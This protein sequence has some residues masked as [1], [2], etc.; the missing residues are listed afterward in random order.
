MSQPPLPWW[1]GNLG[2][3]NPSQYCLNPSHSLPSGT[4]KYHTYSATCASWELAIQVNIAS[5]LH[6]HCHQ[7]RKVD[8]L[9]F[10]LAI[11]VNIA[12]ILHPHSLPSGTVNWTHILQLVLPGNWQ[13][14][15]M[16]PQ[17]FTYIAIG[18]DKLIHCPLNGQSK[19]NIASIL[20]I[21]CHQV[22]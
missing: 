18:Y 22:R 16:L 13:S 12:S 9:S 2:P 4:V 3:G 8:T 10:E 6:I 1:S 11:Q 7:V 17:S 15:S 20:H 14:R 5:I 21:Y 19:V